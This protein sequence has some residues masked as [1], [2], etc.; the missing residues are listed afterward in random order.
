MKKVLQAVLI[1]FFGLAVLGFLVEDDPS[2]ENPIRRSSGSPNT[3]DDQKTTSTGKVLA[4]VTA[5][6]LF[7]AYKAN[8]IAADGAYLGNWVPVHGMVTRIGKDIFDKPF[9]VLGRVNGIYGIQCYFPESDKDALAHLKTGQMVTIV[10]RVDGLLLNVILKG[11]K[12]KS[13]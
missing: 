4:E 10:G 11:C 6:Q 1:C 3:V 8:E 13:T 2:R 12:L 7:D 9:V 5:R